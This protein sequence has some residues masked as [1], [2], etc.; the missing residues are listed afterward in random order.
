MTLPASRGHVAGDEA[1]SPHMAVTHATLAAALQQGDTGPPG[2]G[3]ARLGR[4]PSSPRLAGSRA[5]PGLILRGHPNPGR[6]AAGH[7]TGQAREE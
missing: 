4:S 1:T 2:R 3:H 6:A 5:S 7:R